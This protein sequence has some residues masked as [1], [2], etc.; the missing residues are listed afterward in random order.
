MKRPFVYINMAMTADGK[1]ASAY[2]EYPSFTSEHDSQ[3]M[4]RLRARADALL[5]GAGT[6]RADNPLLRVR[7]AGMREYR[8]ELGKPE[9]LMKVLVTSSARLATG[10]RFFTDDDGG[11]LIVATVSDAPPE[12]LAALAGKAEVWKIGSGEVDLARLLGRLSDE[13]VERLLVEGGGET[14]WRLVREGL[15]DEIYLT[16]APSL[17]GGRAAP[18]FLGGEGFKMRERRMLELLDVRREGEELYCRYAV[19]L[20]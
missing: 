8:K 16:I 12:R 4:D 20:R 9:G 10:L 3:N 7:D 11:R 18:T 19:V 5:V 14:N 15:V 13:G 6:L 2:S 17:L 1:I